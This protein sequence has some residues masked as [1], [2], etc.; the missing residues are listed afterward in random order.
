MGNRQS[1][2]SDDLVT[3]SP[4]IFWLER[5]RHRLICENEA[6][7]DHARLSD[8]MVDDLRAS[9]ASAEKKRDAWHQQW[10]ATMSMLNEARANA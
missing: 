9:L 5:E 1:L 4:Y 8:E 3:M 10:V 7:A 2:P 6:L